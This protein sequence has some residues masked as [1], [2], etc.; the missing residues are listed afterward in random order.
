MVKP[1]LRQAKKNHNKNIAMIQSVIENTGALT[2]TWSSASAVTL[3]LPKAGSIV[4]GITF[5][6]HSNLWSVTAVLSRWC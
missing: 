3:T 5:V 1:T 2:G 6:F 4:Y